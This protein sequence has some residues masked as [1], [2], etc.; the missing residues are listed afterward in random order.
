[1]TYKGNLICTGNDI[2]D[3]VGMISLTGN[4][5]A[6]N[7]YSWILR[8]NGRPNL[9]AI[10]ILA[11]IVYWYRPVE[12]RDEESGRT[13]GYRKKF[14]GD[15]LQKSYEQLGRKF[16]EGKATVKRALDCLEDLGI[17]E[18][19]FRTITFGEEQK[20]MNNVM[21][22]TLLPDGLNKVTFDRPIV[23]NEDPA[24]KSDDTLQANLKRGSEQMYRE[25]PDKAV[26]TNTET[27]TKITDREYNN[28]IYL[29]G[30][31]ECPVADSVL[32]E[33]DRIDEIRAY[34]E[35]VKDQ[36]DFEIMMARFDHRNR[37]VYRELYELICDVVC[38]TGGMIRIGG[39]DMPLQVVK[40]VFMKLKAEHLEYVMESME[41]TVSDIGNIRAYLLTALYRAPQTFQNCISQKVNHD[42]YKY[43]IKDTD[44]SE[45]E[46]GGL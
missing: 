4:L 20:K 26:E 25:A 16:G 24:D 18:R 23:D 27:T 28:P 36:I 9:L 13:T 30:K 15:R 35:F 6:N 22:I 34:R 31:G 43:E 2:V 37:E 11:E 8:K 42:M 33:M 14:K 12:I 32:H 41:R 39:E 44:K 1:M 38:K 5:I 19:E 21:F 10:N 7:W 40:S 46:K 3:E 17:I 29:P 45:T